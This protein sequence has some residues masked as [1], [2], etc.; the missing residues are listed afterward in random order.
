MG[1]IFIF[2]SPDKHSDAALPW[3]IRPQCVHRLGCCAGTERSK[4]EK[5][6]IWA[7]L[8][9]TLSISWQKRIHPIIYQVVAATDN[10]D[11]DDDDDDVDEDGED[12]DQMGPEGFFCSNFRAKFFWSFS[13]WEMSGRVKILH[14]HFKECASKSGEKWCL[15]IKLRNW[16]LIPRGRRTIWILHIAFADG[17]N[18]T[19]AACAASECAIHYSIAFR[20]PKYFLETQ[21]VL[22]KHSANRR[23]TI[24]LKSY[25]PYFN[26]NNDDD[27]SPNRDSKPGYPEL[28]L[29][30]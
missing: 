6:Q 27:I 20:R 4:D 18:Q 11:D 9:L 3:A 21:A 16:W 13:V 22:T 30:I 2:P 23:R 26:D 8:V 10:D 29:F 7:W 1:S 19:R 5:M 28:R 12:E 17:G 25:I 15:K 24:A 14:W